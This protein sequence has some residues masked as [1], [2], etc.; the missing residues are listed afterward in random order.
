MQHIFDVPFNDVSKLIDKYLASQTI[1]SAFMSP[2]REARRLLEKTLGYEVGSNHS[3]FV[4]SCTAALELAALLLDCGSGDEIIMPSNTFV[5]TANAF[6][7]RGAT[8]VF[9]DCTP[10][11][12]N[13]SATN[14]EPAISQKTKAIVPVHYAGV[15]CE[16]E[17]IMELANANGLAVIEDAAQCIGAYFKGHHLGALGDFGTLSFHQTKNVISGEGGALMVKSDELFSKAEVLRE[18][19]TDRSL[20]LRGEVDKYTW[21]DVGSSYVLGDL[22]INTLLPQLRAVEEIT[23]DRLRIWNIY[24][25]GL[26]ELEAEGLLRQPVIP[27]DCQHNAHIYFVVLSSKFNREHVIEKMATKGVQVV[28]HYVPLHSSPAGRKFGRFYG[29]MPVTN[30]IG[31]SLIRLPLYFGLGYEEIQRVIEGLQETLRA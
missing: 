5:S 1:K 7:L 21:Q 25:E 11:T 12:L 18:K 16:M 23:A 20:F 8:P 13:I 4:P 3:L 2:G 6:A 19:G 22:A 14:I 17:G 9:V 30:K 31:S 15:A 29:E 10:G 24:H 28:S 26:A 27:E